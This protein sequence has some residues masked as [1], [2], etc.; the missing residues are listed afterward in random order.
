MNPNIRLVMS[1]IDGTILNDNHEVD[2]DLKENLKGLN[3]KDIPFIL[4]SARSPKGMFHIAEELDIIDNPLVC[5]N[6]ALVLKNA[7]ENKYVPI[8]SHE[9]E[10][11]E[12]RIIIDVI[13]VE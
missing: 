11:E 10:N 4:A 8:V 5:Y 3:E 9:L 1:D 6:G 7:D 12:V 13:K 2:G